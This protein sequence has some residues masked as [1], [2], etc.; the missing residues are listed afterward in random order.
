MTNARLLK[1]KKN[2]N[3]ESS[4]AAV[5]QLLTKIKNRHQ[6]MDIVTYFIISY[7]PLTIALKCTHLF[8][9][10]S[11]HQAKLTVVRMVKKKITFD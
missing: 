7:M 8:H 5:H 11:I 3:K 10:Y 1:R 9:I 4:S 2:N 6:Q